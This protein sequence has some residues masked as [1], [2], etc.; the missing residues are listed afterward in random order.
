MISIIPLLEGTSIPS[1]SD[2]NYELLGTNILDLFLN[3][4]YLLSYYVKLKDENKI[5]LIYREK[6]DLSTSTLSEL[7]LVENLDQASVQMLLY[8]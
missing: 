8:R 5:K 2:T 6:Y 4:S 7:N 1:F 3:N